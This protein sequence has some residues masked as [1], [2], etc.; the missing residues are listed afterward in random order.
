VFQ[1]CKV[2]FRKCAFPTIFPA[3]FHSRIPP[4]PVDSPRRWNRKIPIVPGIAATTN[5]SAKSP[6]TFVLSRMHA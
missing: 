4:H 2:V 5:A 6:A 1:D 3:D